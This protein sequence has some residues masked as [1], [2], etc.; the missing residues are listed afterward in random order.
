MDALERG[1]L[2][3]EQALVPYAGLAYFLC[4][5]GVMF[6][7]LPSNAGAG[8]LGWFSRP[9]DPCACTATT[10]DFQ[11][12]SAPSAGLL[13]EDVISADLFKNMFLTAVLFGFQDFGSCITGS[14]CMYLCFVRR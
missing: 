14:D 12:E 13:M 11:A 4:C 2:R 5:Q 10:V 3:N 7:S 8:S 6:G 1:S 9:S